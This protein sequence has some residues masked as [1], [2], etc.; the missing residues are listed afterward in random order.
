MVN[1]V[2]MNQFQELPLAAWILAAIPRVG[3]FHYYG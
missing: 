2:Q 3:N 1:N